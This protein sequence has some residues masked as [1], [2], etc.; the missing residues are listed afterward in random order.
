MLLNNETLIPPEQLYHKNTRGYLELSTI[1]SLDKATGIKTA[2][3]KLFF[4]TEQKFGQLNGGNVL[5][6]NNVFFLIE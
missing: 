6:L 1:E 5:S 4:I 2:L 3:A